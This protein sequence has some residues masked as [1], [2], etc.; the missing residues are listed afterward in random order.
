MIRSLQRSLVL[1]SV[2]ALVSGGFVWGRARGLEAAP[3][4]KHYIA[5]PTRLITANAGETSS[6][7]SGQDA[8]QD[9]SDVS[10]SE[11]YEVVL[12]KVQHD[13]VEGGGT[14]AKL[15]NGSLAR[16]LASLDDPKTDFLEP[17]MRQARQ[18]AL[19]GRYA[20]IGAVLTIV[21]AKVDKA[22]YRNLTIVDVMPGSPAEKAGLK[23]GDV[24]YS[25]NDRWVIS[26]SFTVDAERIQK[27]QKE[28]SKTDAA[29][30]EEAK[31]IT[32]KFQK[33]IVL[34]KAMTLL[35]TEQGKPLKIAVQRPGQPA[36]VTVS[37]TTGVT[38]V[39]PVE[40]KTLDKQIGWLHVRQ[41]NA[42][43]AQ[44]IQQAIETNGGSLKGLIVDLRGNPGGVKSATSDVD[45]YNAATKLVSLLTDHA[46]A[47]ISR[48]PD[49]KEPLEIAGSKKVNA[50]LIVLVDPGTANLA[51]MVAAT[52]HEA[53]HAKIIGTKT[54]GDPILQLFTV[55]KN[56]TGMEISTAHLLTPAG[57]EWTNGLN[58]DIAATGDDAVKR[59]LAE[60]GA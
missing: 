19:L 17:K 2:A 32:D 58:P 16:M 11:T 59:A 42:R 6:G 44:Q 23:T 51:E 48:K 30:R 41:F 8:N 33:G 39:E 37:L 12:D 38:Q 56:G 45:G 50:P 10:P 40:F 43:A 57:A 21:K 18:D 46:T 9:A 47:M 60:L 26:Y 13:F 53:G 14:D 15:S 35:V 49:K 34:S 1:L 28:K 27:E 5:H 31:Q 7:S 36:N 25:I 55:F 24:I 4:T 54:F 3:L 29:I 22:D 52:L 20:G